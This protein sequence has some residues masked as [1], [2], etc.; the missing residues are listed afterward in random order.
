MPPPHVEQPPRTEVGEMCPSAEG[1]NV[2][3]P[4]PLCTD[5]GVDE[6][7]PDEHR[8]ICMRPRGGVEVNP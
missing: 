6:I 2:S 8:L 1:S 3:A 7:G 5:F 4:A